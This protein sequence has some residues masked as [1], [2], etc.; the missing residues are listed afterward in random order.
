M[1]EFDK[2]QSKDRNMLIPAELKKEIIIKLDE[3]REEFKELQDML[4][5]YFI[6]SEQK[7]I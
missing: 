4:I 5:N 1:N 7:A 6:N 3:E 2:L